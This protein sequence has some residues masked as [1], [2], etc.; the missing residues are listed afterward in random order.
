MEQFETQFKQVEVL[1][2]VKHFMD[3]LDLFN[4]F[5]K[6]VPAAYQVALKSGA[7]SCRAWWAIFSGRFGIFR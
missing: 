2:M 3:E 7:R 1:P 5:K 4:L 6:Y